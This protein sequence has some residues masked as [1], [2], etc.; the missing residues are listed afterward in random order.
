MRAKAQ[1]EQEV[2]KVT[3]EYLN[4]IDAEREEARQKAIA[5]YAANGGN[6]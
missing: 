4:K 6:I 3:K 5:D 1:R 2:Y